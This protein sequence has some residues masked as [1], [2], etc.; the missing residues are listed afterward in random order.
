MKKLCFFFLLM[1][2]AVACERNRKPIIADLTC[3]PETRSAGTIFTLKVLASDED[4]DIVTYHW[5][6]DEGTFLTLTN[7]R[8]VQWKSPATGGGRNFIIKVAVSDGK[9]EVTRDFTILLEQPEL[10][11]LA[12][13]VNFTNFK[14]PIEGVNVTIGGKTATSDANGKFFLAG[15]PAI[16]DTLYAGKQD[17]SSLK[18]VVAIPAND[19]LRI[20]LELGSVNFTTKVSGIITDQE[21]QF[22]DKVTVV[23]LNP[24][25]S[26][27]KLKATTDETGSYRLWYIP[28][29][30]RTIVA[31]KEETEEASYEPQTKTMEFTELQTQLNIVLN[32]TSSTGKFTDPRDQHVY[33]YKKIDASYWMTENLAYLPEVSPPS[34]VSGKISHYYVYG[35]EGT[36]TA[37]AINK[38]EYTNYGVLYN[39]TAL[40]TA[41]PP[42]W[43]VPSD[44]EWD[45]VFYFLEPGAV[46]KMKS[47]SNWNGHGSGN[48]SS[49]LN[50]GPGGQLKYTG[51]FSDL[52][53]GA[54]LWTST[55]WTNGKPGFKGFRFDSDNMGYNAGSDMMG[56][57]VR[58]VRN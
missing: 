37:E 9:H 43:H 45:F 48:N 19:T 47:V 8:E 36:D 1:F 39:R 51:I 6:A 4:G 52:G 58:C 23:A 50:I 29:G 12:G 28:L 34:V 3:I 42:G 22:L 49:G 56:C 33:G 57:S 46:K 11:S 14:I 2:L 17:F 24:D 44:Y 30:T 40:N 10:G 16:E 54:Y 27:S 41:C 5:T 18:S 55:V 26:A 38:S 15:I 25:G 35:Y 32:K 21:G 20:T 13:Q 7:N 53:D 31:S